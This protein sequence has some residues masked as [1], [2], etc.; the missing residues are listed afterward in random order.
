MLR[1]VDATKAYRGTEVVREV[2]LELT[3]GRIVGLVGANGAGKTTTIKMLAGLVEPTRGEVELE[4]QPATTPWARRRV[5]LLT[6]ASALYEEHTPR[7][8]LAFFADLYD[9]PRDIARERS[10][11][12][13]DRLSLAP[14]A[15]EQRIGTM[16]KGMRRKVAVA[17]CLLHDPPVLVLDEPTSGLDPVTAR[18]LDAFVREQRDEGK[19][20]LLSAH[21]LA[22]VEAL[23][24]EVLV[25]HDGEV[26][27]RGSVPELR[28]AA[29]AKRYTVRASVAFPGSSARG[30]AHEATLEDW[31]A[32]E[33]A[34]D[35]VRDGGG[36][37]L[38]VESAL[39]G[40]DEV[41]RELAEA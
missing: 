37:V 17:R 35:A 5:G 10:N 2:D 22:Q 25:M 21:D 28:E 14:D 34:L 41:L 3:P 29:G 20:I 9:V 26:R 16:S 30:G 33:D 7:E 11:R 27:L 12:V 36:E 24:D 32:V 8:Y 40:L 6:E 39:P 38:E 19:A 4:G 31:A 13:F 15:R 18:E 1:A 23:C